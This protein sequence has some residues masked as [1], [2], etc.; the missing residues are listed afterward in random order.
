MSYNIFNMAIA[1]HYKN[2]ENAINYLI[3][4]ACDDIDITNPEIFQSVM[5]RYDLTDDGFESEW[6]YI[7]DKVREVLES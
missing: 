5:K 3:D 1:N 4:L 2:V 7:L 6:Q